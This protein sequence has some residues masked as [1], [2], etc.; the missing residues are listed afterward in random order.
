MNQPNNTKKEILD[1]FDNRQRLFLAGKYHSTRFNRWFE[2]VYDRIE[3]ETEK[4]VREEGLGARSFLRSQGSARMARG[5]TASVRMEKKELQTTTREMTHELQNC[6]DCR[7]IK[8]ECPERF[9]G[10]D[11]PSEPSPEAT[12]LPYQQ[13]QAPHCTTTFIAP[14]INYCPDHNLPSWEECFDLFFPVKTIN[15]HHYIRT[16]GLKDFIRTQIAKAKQDERER[17]EK[18][19]EGAAFLAPHPTETRFIRVVPLS[20][21]ASLHQP[22]EPKT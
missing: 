20:Y 15:H 9:G 17:I 18:E 14:G 16:R 3:A 4:R 11:T 5:A 19:A 7:R 8:C 2:E 13:C 12:T 21:L 22:E 1:E 10:P 6:P